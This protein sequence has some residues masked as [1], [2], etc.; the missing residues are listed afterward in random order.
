MLTVRILFLQVK[1]RSTRAPAINLL[2]K[3]LVFD[4]RTRIDATEALA[5]RGATAETLGTCLAC[6][7]CFVQLHSGEETIVR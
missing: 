4:P 1:R 5:Q 3:M 6:F 7:D 2:E